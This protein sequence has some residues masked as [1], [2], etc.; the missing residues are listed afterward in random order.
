MKAYIQ[1]AV[2]LLFVGAA[3]LAVATLLLGSGSDE[4]ISIVAGYAGGTL[5]V[6]SSIASA[7]W[8][9]RHRGDHQP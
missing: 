8:I 7:I 6:G 4:T 2:V 9:W 3:M 5:A 1:M